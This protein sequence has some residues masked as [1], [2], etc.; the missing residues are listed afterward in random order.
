MDLFDAHDFD[1]DINL[2][3]PLGA[4]SSPIM[5]GAEGGIGGVLKTGPKRSLNLDE[6]K[7]RRGLI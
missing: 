5:I 3:V 2:D 7:K 4:M 6:Y 1:V